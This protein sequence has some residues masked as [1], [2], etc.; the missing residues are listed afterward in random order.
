MIWR[1]LGIGVISTLS[2]DVL[3]G[4][5]AKLGITAPLQPAVT[6]RWVASLLRLQPFHQDIAREAAVPHELA[7]ALPVH[8][9]IGVTLAALY[10]FVTGELEVQPRAFGLALAFGLVTNLLPW[11]IMFPSMGY[12]FFGEHGPEGTR[13]FV[14]SLVNHTCFGVGIY[15]GV[16]LLGAP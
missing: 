3:G 11:L 6:G 7:L 10:L 4:L 14:T 2:M 12:G 15:A 1:T 5:A 16:R 9:L 8:Y 13:L